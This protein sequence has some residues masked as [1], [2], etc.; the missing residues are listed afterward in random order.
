MFEKKTRFSHEVDL[1]NVLTVNPHLSQQIL[2]KQRRRKRRGKKSI[3]ASK[4]NLN[5]KA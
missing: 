3:S 5:A 4:Y 2:D 1:E